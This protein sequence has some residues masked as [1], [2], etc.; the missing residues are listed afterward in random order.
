MCSIHYRKIIISLYAIMPSYKSVIVILQ[1]EEIC[2]HYLI[3][4]KID[5]SVTS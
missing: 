2:A 3:R 4:I 5:I 1:N